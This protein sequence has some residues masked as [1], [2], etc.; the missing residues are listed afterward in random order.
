LIFVHE[1]GHLITA[2]LTR[3]QVNEFALGMGPKIFGFR[4]GETKYQLRAIPIGGFCAME[5]EDE[6]SD[7]PRA[8]GNR[9]ARVRAL[10]LCAGSLMNVLLAIVL[11]SIIIFVVGEPITRI[12]QVSD[13]SPAFS[14]GLRAG[15][16]ITAIDGQPVKKYDDVLVIVSGIAAA[17]EEETSAALENAKA[18]APAEGEAL[19]DTVTDSGIP[20][21]LTVERAGGVQTIE[22]EFYYDAAGALKIG[23]TPELGRSAGYFF[24][25]F[26]YGVQATGNMAR[27]MYEVLG[28]LVTGQAGMD[29]L[30]GP[31]G[32]VKT[33]GETAQYGFIYVVQLAAL[34]SL[35]LGIV[36]LLPFPALDGG[37]LV[38][39]VIRKVTGR[40][41]TD[42]IEGR[43]HLVGIICLFAL[44]AVITLQDI[45]RFILH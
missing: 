33:V 14:D 44:M 17:H 21:T 2:K 16:R 29:Q 39:L 22:T 43:V 10:V 35:N 26:G 11:L 5:G 30:T 9:P 36:N 45:N 8:F 42:A 40:K 41:I 34:I 12:A 31:V 37:R 20:V 15:D 27:L 3:I 23:I 25:S 24:R 4:R 7:N 28:D 32:I 13:A 38:F 18:N 1:T 19:P 6:E